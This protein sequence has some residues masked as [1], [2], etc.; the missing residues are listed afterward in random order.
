ML[1]ELLEKYGNRKPMD[2]GSHVEKTIPIS[3]VI[4]MM[5]EYHESKVKKLNI[6]DIEGQTKQLK[7]YAN[8]LQEAAWDYPDK[9]FDELVDVF[10]R[11]NC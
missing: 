3:A 4:R 5:E 8:W 1:T 2:L 6:P 11:E 10:L 9:D 7:A